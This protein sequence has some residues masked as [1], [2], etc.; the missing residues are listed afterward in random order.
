M[1]KPEEV[2][3]KMGG[4]RLILPQKAKGDTTVVSYNDACTNQ[5]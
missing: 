4:R 2:G 5:D 3:K 1:D